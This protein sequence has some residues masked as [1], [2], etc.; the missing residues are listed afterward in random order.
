MNMLYVFHKEKVWL[1]EQIKTYN[2][3]NNKNLLGIF[4]G[5]VSN[6]SQNI[7]R[8]T[9]LG[10]H[11][12]ENRPQGREQPG[13]PDDED[14][15]SPHRILIKQAIKFKKCEGTGYFGFSRRE[16][17]NEHGSLFQTLKTIWP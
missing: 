7:C 15:S 2:F 5:G 4:L 14:G 10:D 12:L 6:F 9:H 17:E 8:C 1:L 3:P 16:K 11:G 13:G